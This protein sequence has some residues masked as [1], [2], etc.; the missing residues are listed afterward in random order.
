MTDCVRSRGHCAQDSELHTAHRRDCTVVTES[1]RQTEQSG[2]H[3]ELNSYTDYQPEA[4]SNLIT[5]SLSQITA[6]RQC[7]QYVSCAP[8]CV[9][10]H[11]GEMNSCRAA[12]ARSARKIG[13][14]L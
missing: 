8:F 1:G 12:C 11:A 10:I 5:A 3:S 2:L 13:P 9:W 6:G 14:A 7:R 4:P